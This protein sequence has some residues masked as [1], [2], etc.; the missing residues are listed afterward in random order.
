MASVAELKEKGNGYVKEKNYQEA[1]E[2]YTAALLLDPLNHAIL[3]N[4]SLTFYRQ[5]KLDEALNDAN[6]CIEVAPDFAKGYLRKAT[7]L[8]R[9]ALYIEA[10]GAAEEGYKR[11]QSDYVCTECVSQWLQAMQG[12][13]KPLTEQISKLPSGFLILSNEMLK[14]YQNISFC[15]A[16]AAGMTQ[17]LMISYLLSNAKE[18]DHILGAFGHKVPFSM[19]NWINSLSLT[20]TDPQTDSIIS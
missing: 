1:T 5:G 16:S 20:I 12:V 18:L 10:M 9:L 15:R 3:S 8:N 2:C 6:K 14:I 4:R 17:K 19:F 7:A 13:I 11:R